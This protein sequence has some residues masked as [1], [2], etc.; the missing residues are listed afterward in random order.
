VPN[1]ADVAAYVL[2]VLDRDEIDAFEDHLA[3]CRKCAL[4]LRDFAALPDLLDDADASGLL[5]GTTPE[6][7]D[8]RSVRA[9]L[10]SVS[11]QRR[12][13]RKEWIFAAAAGA[14][15]LVAVS[16][17]T[18]AGLG[19]GSD[20]S[21]NAGGNPTGAPERSAVAQNRPEEFDNTQSAKDPESGATVTVG[22]RTEPWGTAIDLQV[23]GALGASKCVL[24]ALTTTGEKIPVTSWYATDSPPTAQNPLQLGGNVAVRYYDIA[25]YVVTDDKGSTLL[26]IAD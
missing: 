23:D 25:R 5:R 14:V 18:A 26:E 17:F 22:S 21:T 10:D 16:A 1:H 24:L 15:L 9:M 19:S 7:P 12:K 4:D 13:R 20:G 6:R 8:G 2:G 11:A 3:E